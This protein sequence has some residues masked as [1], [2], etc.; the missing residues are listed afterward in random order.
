M[1]KRKYYQIVPV[2]LCLELV[3]SV[4]YLGFVASVAE[5]PNSGGACSFGCIKFAVAFIVADRF[6]WVFNAAYVAELR[7]NRIRLF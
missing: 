3:I 6:S 1:I 5:P 2:R 4:A 7:P